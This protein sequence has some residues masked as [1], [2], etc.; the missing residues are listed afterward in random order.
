[1][2]GCRGKVPQPGVGSRGSLF[3]GGV[4]SCHDVRCVVIAKAVSVCRNSD[5]TVWDT[6]VC[7]LGGHFLLAPHSAPN[8]DVEHLSKWRPFY[9]S[10]VSIVPTL[11]FFAYV[12]LIITFIWL[13]TAQ[14][15]YI[16]QYQPLTE[17]STRNISRG[18]K[19]ACAYVWKRN[20]LHVP[21]VWKSGSL[22]LLEPS[23]PVQACNGI[24][25]PLPI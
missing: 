14:S 6:T 18:V 11:F 19:L 4:K 8:L 3:W 24:A 17:M 21:I 5:C 16:S 25:L 2:S 12:I 1:V 10:S 9:D 23:G 22:T 20:H 15:A 13:S 7:C